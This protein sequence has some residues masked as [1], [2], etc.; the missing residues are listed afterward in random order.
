MK[1]NQYRDSGI[2]NIGEIAFG[3]HICSFFSDISF[4]NESLVD[5]FKKGLENDELCIWVTS[6]NFNKNMVEVLLDK[7][8]PQYKDA[9]NK[10][11]FLIVSYKE[12]Y[13]DEDDNLSKALPEKFIDY[14]EIANK[15]NPI[16]IVSDLSWLDKNLINDFIKLEI[17]MNNFIKDYKIFVLCAYSLKNVSE[18]EAIQISNIHDVVLYHKN[19]ELL[20]VQNYERI[21]YEHEKQTLG[22]VSRGIIHD[23]KKL[24][25]VIKG[26]TDL[27][28]SEV[29]K[30]S[31]IFD[32]LNEIS[33]SIK[34]SVNIISQLPKLYY[35][36]S[37]DVIE[38]DINDIIRDVIKI[39]SYYIT[40][41]ITIDLNLERNLWSIKG[42]ENKVGQILLNLIINAKESIKDK[43]T[44]S[45][46]TTNIK[47]NKKNIN[48]IPNSKKGR[49]IRISIKDT[50]IGMNE[51]TV[52]NLFE[53]FFTTKK[54][55]EGSGLGLSI[56]KIYVKELKGWINIY[57]E[58]NKGSEFQIFFPTI[59]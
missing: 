20:V 25:T 15:I 52:G 57:S 2:E 41:K 37:I 3:T 58:L 21:L 22:L 34:N 50:G 32:Y 38:L 23:F 29:K 18:F 6:N 53:P 7:K 26:Y 36:N 43:G 30:N 1:S 11:K 9:L 56:V 47:I 33:R 12:F 54:K 44:I 5:Y 24:I 45:I 8:L 28:K 35:R 46:T 39:F 4:F 42:N 19:K 40:E 14:A 27:A 51:E 13:F 31:K 10:G 17:L 49:F 55:K 59:N 16:R 48:K